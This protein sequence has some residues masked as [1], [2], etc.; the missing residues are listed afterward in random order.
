MRSTESIIAKTPR[1]TVETALAEATG[2][3]GVARVGGGGQG[4]PPTSSIPYYL[5]RG[6]GTRVRFSL[7]IPSVLLPWLK[8]I[9]TL[10]GEILATPLHIVCWSHR[11]RDLDADVSAK[12]DFPWY[13]GCGARGLMR[14]IWCDGCARIS[15]GLSLRNPPLCKHRLRGEPFEGDTLSGSVL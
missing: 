8:K 13:V 5:C 2:H 6:S 7:K 14:Q 11:F 15:V 3:R 10:R 9:G 12:P 1:R 4:V